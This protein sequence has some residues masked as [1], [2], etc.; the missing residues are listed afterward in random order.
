MV[1]FTAFTGAFLAAADVSVGPVVFFTVVVVVVVDVGGFLAA[2]PE[3]DVLSA[4]VVAV[5]D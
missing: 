3:R 2:T 5:F 1:F 4:P